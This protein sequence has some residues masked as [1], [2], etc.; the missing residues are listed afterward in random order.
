M[1]GAHLG[2]AFFSAT[3]DDDGPKGAELVHLVQPPT[4]RAIVT[5]GLSIEEWGR[6]MNVRYSFVRTKEF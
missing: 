4:P 6:Q 1:K 5:S 3:T 2:Q